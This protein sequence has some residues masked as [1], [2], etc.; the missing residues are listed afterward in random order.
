MRIGQTI[1]GSA[2]LY[3]FLVYAIVWIHDA[4]AH[5]DLSKHA[6]AILLLL[7]FPIFLGCAFS[8]VI[9]IADGRG[10]RRA[11]GVTGVLVAVIVNVLFLLANG[12]V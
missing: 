10:K 6:Q 12:T 9:F 8:L 2:V 5:R 11:V 1:T 7:V 4:L 3:P